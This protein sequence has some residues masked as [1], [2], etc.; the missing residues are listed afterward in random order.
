MEPGQ[1]WLNWLLATVADIVPLREENRILVKYGLSALEKTTRPGLIALLEK[2][3][4]R[5]KPITAG[6]IGFILAPRL[7]SA[8][9]INSARQSVALLLSKNTEEARLLAEAL[10]RLNDERREI[11]ES[12]YEQ[13]LLALP[14]LEA[15]RFILVHDENWHEG[16]IGI[17]ASRLPTSFIAPPSWYPG[18]GAGQGFRSQQR[19]FD[20]Y[21]A[22][23]SCSSQLERFGG[24]RMAAGLGLRRDK[25]TSFCQA[26]Q[27]YMLG[28]EL[29]TLGKKIYP[30]DL[31][32]DETDL[33]LKLWSEIEQLAPFGE[34]NPSPSLV[35]RGSPL[36]EFWLV[37]A[38]ETHFKFK[39]GEKHLDAI[40]FNGADMMKP[41]LKICKQDL[42]FDLAENNF[43]GRSSLQLKIRVSNRPGEM[44]RGWR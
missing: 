17:V 20:L 32:V 21:A 43:K 9:R 40:A 6:H 36:H 16:V 7:N 18:R 41:G 12:I 44:I 23:Q 14:D 10:C 13:A 22:L 24:H 25:L 38:N 27:E 34:G 30:V 2:T 33:S 39:T 3:G 28:Q 42:L 15:Q 4:L 29:P 19:R 11:E 37:G 1:D 8:G 26:L 31:E 35:L 5:G